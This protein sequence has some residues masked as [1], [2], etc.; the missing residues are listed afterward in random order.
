MYYLIYA[1]IAG[2]DA[3]DEDDDDDNKYVIE[4]DEEELPFACIICKV[5]LCSITTTV[6]S[7][8]TQLHLFIY[9]R[10]SLSSP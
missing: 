4:S 5:R 2:L 9:I 7:Y 1:I 8:I 6:P 10:M 3:V